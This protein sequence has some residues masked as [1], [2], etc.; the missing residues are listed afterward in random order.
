MKRGEPQLLL[1]DGSVLD[2]EWHR[3]KP[4]REVDVRVPAAPVGKP[5]TVLSR[6]HFH[7]GD[8]GYVIL[9]P[10]E[11]DAT[12][13]KLVETNRLEGEEGSAFDTSKYR[14]EDGSKFGVEGLIVRVLDAEWSL[15]ALLGTSGSTKFDKPGDTLSEF[16]RI[17]AEKS[18]FE[19]NIRFALEETN[20]RPAD[21][22]GHILQAYG[23]P[24]EV[25][26]APSEL[27]PDPRSLTSRY[28]WA[29]IE[30]EIFWASVPAQG[31]VGGAGRLVHIEALKAHGSLSWPAL[32]RGAYSV[33]GS[34]WSVSRLKYEF[35]QYLPPESPFHW[36]LQTLQ[37]VSFFEQVSNDAAM[38]KAWRTMAP[39]LFDAG[40]FM[41]EYNARSRHT[42]SIVGGH[43]SKGSVK[44]AA[45]TKKQTADD[46]K[47][48]LRPFVV[49]I[50]EKNPAI[51]NIDVYRN[52]KVRAFARRGEGRSGQWEDD[53]QLRMTIK[54]HRDHDDE[55]KPSAASVTKLVA[56]IRD[57]LARKRS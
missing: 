31:L 7:D 51:S 39:M 8:G 46:W 57:E 53:A 42:E 19:A 9:Q 25:E 13:Q 23:F 4:S 2:L 33:R 30:G 34:W 54:R 35:D 43:K 36:A 32:L 45:D 11:A 18:I 6:S 27:D 5:G 56:T 52:L 47:E 55:T 29:W 1:P 37:I 24:L 22:A 17:E 28:A 16:E 49:R 10:G 44:K 15:S 20:P 41:A 40:R 50:L 26:T 12:L 38:V 14:I 48:A 3:L 21:Q